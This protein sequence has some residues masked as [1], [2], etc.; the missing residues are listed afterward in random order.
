MKIIEDNHNSGQRK[1]EL[2]VVTDDVDVPQDLKDML[3]VYS[4]LFQAASVLP[5]R[6]QY[7]HQIQL[8]PGATP[9]NI[10]LYKYS[11]A[12]KDEIEKP[13]ADMLQHGI[14]KT[15]VSPYASPVLLVR[16]KDIICLLLM[17]SLMN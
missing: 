12:Q 15:S 11:P 5:H 8:L 13:L 9:V 4:E 14:I 1:N 7:D 6:R 2:H 10:R 16:K 17:N 3:V